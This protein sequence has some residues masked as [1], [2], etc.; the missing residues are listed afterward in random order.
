M[1]FGQTF[2][3]KRL[4]YGA[5]PDVKYYENMLYLTFIDLDMQQ[6]LYSESSDGGETFS[7]PKL[8]F[9]VDWELSPYEERPTPTIDVDAEKVIITWKMYD[10]DQQKT[11]WVATDQGKDGSFEISSQMIQIE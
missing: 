6:I 4:F 11:A 9:E 8:I 3:K 10:R 1:D 7:E 2:E 5:R